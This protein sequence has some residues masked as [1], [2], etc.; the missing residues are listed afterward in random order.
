LTIDDF[1]SRWTDRE[2]GQERA[3]YAL[4]L[5]ELCDVLE[6]PRPHPADADSTTNDYVFERAVKET[7]R[8]G[9]TSAKRIDLYKRDAFILEAKQSR[10]Q[11]GTKEVEGQGMLFEPAPG[12]RGKRTASKAWDVLMMNARAQAENYVRLLPANHT[13]P[14]FVIV[15][16]VGHCFEVYAAREPRGYAMKRAA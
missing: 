14:P 7:A 5:S 3:N 2:G 11:G 9:A 16:D 12:T 10:Q 6:V 1:I 13:A 4:F 8:E 15:C